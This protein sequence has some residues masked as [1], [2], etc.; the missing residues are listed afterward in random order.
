MLNLARWIL[1]RAILGKGASNLRP[2]RA[3]KAGVNALVVG[4]SPKLT[5]KEH[6]KPAKIPN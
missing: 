4:M 2:T 1:K 3:E 5:E 6:L